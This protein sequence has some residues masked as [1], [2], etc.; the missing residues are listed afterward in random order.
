MPVNLRH[1]LLS[2]I[3]PINFGPEVPQ[4][5]FHGVY[6]WKIPRFPWVKPMACPANPTSRSVCRSSVSVVSSPGSSGKCLAEGSVGYF[7]RSSPSCCLWLLQSTGDPVAPK[8]G[9]GPYQSWRHPWKSTG[10]PWSFSGSS[11]TGGSNMV[12]NSRITWVSCVESV[13]LVIGM[14]FQG[15][16]TGNLSFTSESRLS[17][18]GN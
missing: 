6:P 13:K 5:F 1:L 17:N 11:T 12:Q 18:S 9:H 10:Y 14:V 2:S 3:I 16:S 8:S 7:S 15:K 4:S